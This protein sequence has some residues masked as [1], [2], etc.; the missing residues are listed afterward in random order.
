[1][2]EATTVKLQ[3]LSV[4]NLRNCRTELVVVVVVVV[5][6]LLLIIIIIII[7]ASACLPPGKERLYPLSMRRDPRADTDVVEERKRRCTH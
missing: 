7:H 4:S 6:L 2:M 5:L 1:M 3:C